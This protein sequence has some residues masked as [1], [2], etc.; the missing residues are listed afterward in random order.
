VNLLTQYDP[1]LPFPEAGDVRE[2]SARMTP[3]S[4]MSNFHKHIRPDVRCNKKG[5]LQ[6]AGSNCKR[7]GCGLISEQQRF[8]MGSKDRLLLNYASTDTGLTTCFF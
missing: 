5:L 3:A 1:K 2:R 8:S 4:C 6:A 7:E